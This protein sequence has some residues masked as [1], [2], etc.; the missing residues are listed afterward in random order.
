MK[1]GAAQHA[2]EIIQK[3]I[4][5][6][7][8]PMGKS[9]PGQRTLAEELGV[10]RP[11]IREAISALECLGMLQVEPGRGVF[12]RD[13]QAV[14]STH[15]RFAN[16]YSLDNVYSVRASLESLSV[17]LATQRATLAEIRMLELLTEKF[18]AAVK[19][20]DLLA[21][22]AAD[23]AF[24]RKLAEMS[25]NPLLLEMLDAFDVVINECRNLAFRDVTAKHRAAPVLEHR[26]IIEAIKSGDA[27]V[28]SKK[29]NMHILQAQARAGLSA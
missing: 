2:A 24:H 6:D 19:I 18:Q 16:Q 27:I 26:Q 14:H 22:S 13:P 12:V 23:R 17:F 11:A 3:R 15:W 7:E 20:A 5:S 28:A 4:R 1:K 9:L 25:C 10:G 29:M 8:Y 21:M